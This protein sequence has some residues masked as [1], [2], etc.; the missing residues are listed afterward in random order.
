V[1]AL[2]MSNASS[3][4][5][6]GPHQV[7]FAEARAGFHMGLVTATENRSAPRNVYLPRS[8]QGMVHFF[9]PS[10][11][12]KWVLLVEML[13]AV[14][15]PC[16]VVPFDG[17]SEGKQ[18]GPPEAQCTAV[19][20][21]PD[22]RWMYFAAEVGAESHLW[23][24]R[25]PDGAP[26]QL[27]SGLNQEWTVTAD[28]DGRSLITAVGNV[29]ST[30]W[31]QG[32]GGARPVSV[33]GYAYRPLVSP[34]E[35]KVYYLVKRAAKGTIW[36][37]ELWA[38]DLASGRNELALPGFQVETFDISHDG[39]FAALAA[40]DSS[41][42]SAIWLAAIDRSQPPRKLTPDGEPNESR[43]FFGASGRIYFVRESQNGRAFYRMNQDGSGRQRLRPDSDDFLVN[44]SPDERW[45]VSWNLTSDVQLLPL[46]GGEPQ[47]LCLC[48]AGPIFHDSPRIGWSRDGKQLFVNWGGSMV[49]LGTTVFSWKEVEARLSS[50][51]LTL[52]DLRRL[53][54]TRQIQE[55]SI[56]PGATGAR[57][58][59]ARQ[60][61]QSNLFRIRLPH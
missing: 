36:T 22:G 20:W 35:T 50:A 10:P 8:P 19:A 46:A 17:S 1:P 30:V 38:A 9:E 2:L 12:G 27:T 23:R 21:S 44:I 52:A 31:F 34:D 18:V 42:R 43:P 15:Q 54:G 4:R 47:P 40:F 29:Q 3:M 5:W 24:Q 41:G 58:A 11:D 28:P 51:S 56:A 37:G 14:W 25:F 33:E 7:L 13:N 55:I 26:E 59:F 6:A 39:K 49:G 60:A 32:D 57:Y 45:A 16:R 53:P 61:E 48:G